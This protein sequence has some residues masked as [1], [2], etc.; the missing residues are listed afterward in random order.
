MAFAK[1]V[2]LGAL[3][4]K[5]FCPFDDALWISAIWCEVFVSCKILSRLRTFEP[6]KIYKD[7][8]FEQFL[9]KFY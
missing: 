8:H 1:L 3:A 7:V 2:L 5:N 6:V 9:L 4:N